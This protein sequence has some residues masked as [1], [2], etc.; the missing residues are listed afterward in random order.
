MDQLKFQ[1]E[2]SSFDE[3]IALSKLEEAKAL[4]RTKELEY[5]KA[6]FQMEW[7]TMVAKTQEQQGEKKNAG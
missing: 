3:K 5:R 4:E 1:L 2:M 7:L 6:R